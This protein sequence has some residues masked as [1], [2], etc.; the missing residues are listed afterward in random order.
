VAF[1]KSFTTRDSEE[2][3][4][5]AT[6]FP[7]SLRWWFLTGLL[8]GLVVFLRPDTGLFAAATGFTLVLTTLW[9]EFALLPRPS[10]ERVDSL[11]KAA[12]SRRTPKILA[13][14]IV[15]GTV[16]S[17]AFVL[18]LVPWTIRNWRVFHIFQPLSP[19]HGE[20]PGEFVARGYNLW[21]RTW[22]DE[23]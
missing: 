20:M 23:D 17:L 14:L 11:P 19:A 6:R 15:S 21:L 5:L 8:G 16:F 22:L 10:V 13:Q 2:L 4:S 7:A 3:P 1:R 18:V 9:R 12:T